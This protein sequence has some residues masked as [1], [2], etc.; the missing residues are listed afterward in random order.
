MFGR[1]N[2]APCPVRIDLGELGPKKQDLR[3]IV[4]PQYQGNERAG[5]AVSRS[6]TSA[7][8]IKAECPLANGEK[9]C[10]HA[11]PNPHVA[12]ADFGI[13]QEFENDREQQNNDREIE[14]PIGSECNYDSARENRL[15]L[16]T[17]TLEET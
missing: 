3:R 13:G 11:G 5:C 10:G 1:F 2:V 7:T 15:H 9:N 8:Q 4:H 16:M 14:Y 17:E 6:S 12:P